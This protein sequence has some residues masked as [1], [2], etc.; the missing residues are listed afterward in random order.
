MTRSAHLI[1]LPDSEIFPAEIHVENGRIKS[2]KRVESVP[3]DAGYIL[4]G[5]V[6]AHVHVESSM[7]PPAEFARMAVVHGTVGSVSDPHEIA[8]VLGGAGVSYM[9]EEARRSPFKFCLG[10]PSCVP[11][12]GFETAGAAMNAQ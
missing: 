5:F 1:H 4:P 12:T 8:N 6:D 9:L 10:A 2:I 7:L 11:A 3:E